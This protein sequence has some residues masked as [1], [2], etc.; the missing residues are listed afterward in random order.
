MQSGV[1]RKRRSRK[2]SSRVRFNDEVQQVLC[3][4]EAVYSS[5][6]FLPFYEAQDSIMTDAEIYHLR[7]LLDYYQLWDHTIL[8]LPPTHLKPTEDPYH[9]SFVS[10]S[11]FY[12]DNDTA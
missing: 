8:P 2:L 7:I 3:L 6:N 12:V 11:D 1:F 9:P 5:T 4:P 10:E